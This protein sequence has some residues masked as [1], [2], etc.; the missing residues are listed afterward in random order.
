MLLML[1]RDRE[2]KFIDKDKTI[3]QGR[4]DVISMT[5]EELKELSI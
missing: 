4:T 5:I 1:I 2:S 3:P